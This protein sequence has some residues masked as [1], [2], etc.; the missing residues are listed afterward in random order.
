MAHK[1][2]L[3]TGN[4]QKASMDWM[5]RKWG[6]YVQQTGKHIEERANNI[7]FQISKLQVAKSERFID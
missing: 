6:E 2:C 4:Y 7:K 5:F 3:F 1:Y